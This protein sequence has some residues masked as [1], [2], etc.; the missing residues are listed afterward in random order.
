MDSSKPSKVTDTRL[1]VT[2]I[3][4]P[5]EPSNYIDRGNISDEEKTYTL[6]LTKVYR[7]SW[8]TEGGFVAR[9]LKSE[10]FN[11]IID[12]G[13][14]NGCEVRTWENQGGVLARAVKYYYKD[15]L[16]G[17]F[18][19]WCTELKAEAEKRVVDQKDDT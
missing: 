5:T 15:V 10:R 17:K 7:I 2:D 11:E 19:G 4:N 12:L 6:D 18:Q 8:T 16:M 3:S 1:R 13:E 14:G 9:G